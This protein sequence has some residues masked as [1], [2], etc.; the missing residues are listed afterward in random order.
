[1]T[2][3]S[4]GA[5]VSLFVL[6]PYPSTYWGLSY[7]LVHRRARALASASVLMP[8]AGDHSGRLGGDHVLRDGRTFFL[9]LH[10]LHS[11][12]HSKYQGKF[13]T[14]DNGARWGWGGRGGGMGSSP[15]SPQG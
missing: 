9:Q 6:P 12:H 1:M 8:T 15:G 7:I 10:L 4:L 11:A 2:S 3:V 13:R 14:M 5:L